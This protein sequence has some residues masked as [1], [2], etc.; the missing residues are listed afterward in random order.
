MAQLGGVVNGG[1]ARQ[2]GGVA[3]RR[4]SAALGAEI[5]WRVLSAA[6]GSAACVGE[7]NKLGIGGARLSAYK[8]RHGGSVSGGLGASAAHGGISASKW[9]RRHRGIGIIIGIMA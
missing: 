6:L 7:T 3:W 2:R 1:S 4:R 8:W 9:R 5:M